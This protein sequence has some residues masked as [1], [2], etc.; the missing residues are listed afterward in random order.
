M[1]R[2]GR[3]QWAGTAPRLSGR[4]RRRRWL[5]GDAARV[6]VRCVPDPVVTG[7]VN[8]AVLDD[9]VRLCVHLT[10]TP[11]RRHPAPPAPPLRPAPRAWPG[12]AGPSGPAV[13]PGQADPGGAGAAHHR[14][15]R[16]AGLRPGGLASVCGGTAR[17]PLAGPSCPGRRYSNDI[18]PR[19]ATRS[20]P[21]PAL[22]VVRGCHQPPPHARSTTCGTRPT[23]VRQPGQLHIA[24]FLPPPGDD[25]PDGLDLVRHPDGTTTPGTGTR[26]KSCAATAPAG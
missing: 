19:S 9:L 13:L 1:D 23:A 16:R 21:G 7:E 4:R 17:R 10:A 20:G 8:Y 18:R 26:A 6:R 3:A 22:P 11:P 25:P 15:G 5:D 14:P 12:P 24:L 2:G